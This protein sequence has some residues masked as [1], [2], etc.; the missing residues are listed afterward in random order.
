MRARLV[1]LLA[2]VL[3]A[4][5]GVV[6]GAAPASAHGAAT[7]GLV[8]V[9]QTL[10]DRELTVL[11]Y[12]PASGQ[13]AMPVR[14]VA[15]GDPPPPMVVR[16]VRVTGPE[17]GRATA[18]TV[19][20]PTSDP[21]T[22][23]GTLPIAEPGAWEVVL[24]LG[25]DTARIPLSVSAPVTPP[26]V[27]PVRGG[28]IAAVVFLLG[29]A[30]A[31]RSRRPRLAVASG[32]AAV[33]GLTVVVTTSLLASSIPAPSPA[34]PA[35]S[36]AP[37]AGMDMSGTG[38]DMSGAG[39]S[40][41]GT[42][43]V[44]LTTAVTRASPAGPVDLA[45]VL[46]DG[47]TGAPVDDLVVHDDALIHLAVVGPE[48]RLRHVHPVR[49]APGRFTVRLA[50]PAAGAYGVFAETE[51]ADGGHQVS[52]SAFS[53][54]GA[55]PVP[56]LDTADGPGPRDVAGMRVDT[57]VAPAVAGQPTRVE[58][59]FSQDGAPVRDLQAW[60]G[61]AGHLM[62]IG[63]GRGVDPVATD[64]GVSFAHVHDMQAPGPSGAY[65]PMIAFTYA[66]PAPGRY[67]LWAQVQRDWQL[68]TVPL[69]LEVAPSPV[70]PAP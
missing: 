20:G 2:V 54:D 70:A 68:V 49:T 15:Q 35:P 24:S 62:I 4:L 6:A 56:P 64:P 41:H 5:L 28:L 44:V 11:L 32:A 22:V 57:A 21:R 58:L 34:A 29:A 18:E 10:G 26:W 17:A 63:P 66:F 36:A 19:V 8:S 40:G 46:T 33:V 9:A 12:P 23:A 39:M 3:G 43:A 47:S 25:G 52:R 60:L 31:A 42:G 14:V 37:M 55:P 13:G 50:L 65:G 27:W 1:A 53:L 51:R 61:M 38:M 48:R 30:I 45:L 59:V 67:Q 69:T 7:P 16:A